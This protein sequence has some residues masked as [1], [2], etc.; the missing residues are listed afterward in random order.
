MRC[1]GKN[2]FPEAKKGVKKI[3][4]QTVVLQK[5]CVKHHLMSPA[6]IGLLIMH[7]YLVILVSPLELK[8]AYF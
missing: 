2:N 7:T 6:Y 4:V 3:Q 1:K 5:I 8:A